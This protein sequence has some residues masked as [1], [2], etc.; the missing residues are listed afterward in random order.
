ML[1]VA[2]GQT[3]AHCCFKQKNKKDIFYSVHYEIQV[4]K[5]RVKLLYRVQITYHEG[6]C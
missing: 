6:K 3:F 1:D 2:S 5:E 4:F